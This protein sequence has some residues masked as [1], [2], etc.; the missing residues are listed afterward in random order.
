MS[1]SFQIGADGGTQ[2]A[3]NDG[4]AAFGKW[5]D[6]LDPKEY[7]E[8]V[9]L[10]EHGWSQDLAALASQLGTASIRNPPP[11]ELMHTIQE[12]ITQLHERNPDAVVVTITQGTG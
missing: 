7:V 12:M 2:I 8:I 11:P 4:Y 10:Y 5:A 9:R 6:A 3:S 1:Y